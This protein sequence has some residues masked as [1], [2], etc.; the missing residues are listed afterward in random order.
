MSGTPAHEESYS[1]WYLADRVPQLAIGV[2]IALCT[3][4]L[5]L[6]LFTSLR[7]YGYFRDELYYLD[8][9]RQQYR[10]RSGVRRAHLF[11]IGNGANS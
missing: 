11:R 8:L 7:H 1:E 2:L 3:C 9:A 4:K 6:H 5:L 10:L